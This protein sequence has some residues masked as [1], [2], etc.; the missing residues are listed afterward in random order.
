MIR[1]YSPADLP[2]GSPEWHAIRRLRVGASETA[3]IGGL[4]PHRS[5]AD[6]WADK[7]G[8]PRARTFADQAIALQIGHALEPLTLRLWS[9]E[10]GIATERGPTLVELDGFRAASLDAWT[11]D[12]EPVDG[13]VTLPFSEPWEG[14]PLHIAIQLHQQADLTEALTGRRLDAAHIAQLDLRSCQL[15]AWRLPLDAEAREWYADEWRTYPARW[16]TAFVAG[17]AIPSEATCSQVYH[18]RAETVSE[19]EPTDEEAELLTAFLAAETAGAEAARAAEAAKVHRDELRDDLARRLGP[20]H[21][22]P[23]LHLVRRSGRFFIAPKQ[24][25]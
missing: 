17:D 7:T 20:N 16:W 6:V 14:I 15:R 18:R 11:P 19:R 23:G 10:T 4:S 3:A 21:I 1:A 22:L 12:R 2:Q 25:K 13:K 5:P 24:E 8:R 9:Q